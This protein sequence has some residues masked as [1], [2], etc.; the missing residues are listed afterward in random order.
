MNTHCDD[1]FG[2]EAST[3]TYNDIDSS[4]VFF[5]RN[6]KTLLEKNCL[7]YCIIIKEEKMKVSNVHV[8]NKCKGARF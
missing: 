4:S 8:I 5:A 2:V 1:D 3:N 7:S 6:H